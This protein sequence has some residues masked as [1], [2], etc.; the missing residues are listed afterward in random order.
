MKV[1]V[2]CPARTRWCISA[3]SATDGYVSGEC[4]GSAT[5]RKGEGK[6]VS[7]VLAAAEEGD[8][9]ASAEKILSRHCQHEKQLDPLLGSGRLEAVSK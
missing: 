1:A 7:Q 9:S 8:S 2:I 5:G 4:P 6:L 3:V